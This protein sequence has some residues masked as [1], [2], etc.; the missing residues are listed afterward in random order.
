MTGATCR[1]HRHVSM[2]VSTKVGF[3]DTLA[4][5]VGPTLRPNAFAP[6]SE[7]AEITPV[8]QMAAELDQ[9]HQPRAQVMGLPRTP[10]GN[11]VGRKHPPRK[12]AVGEPCG[13]RIEHPQAVPM[14]ARLQWGWGHP[15]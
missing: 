12:L 15:W 4:R 1:R 13:L 8:A 7:Q 9:P 10:G 3:V 6:A 5:G 2:D 14:L 11:A